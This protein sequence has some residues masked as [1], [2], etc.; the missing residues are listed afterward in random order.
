MKH[1]YVGLDDHQFWKRSP[2]IIDKSDLDP[3]TG[4]PFKISSIDK[5]VTAGSCF[6]QHVARFMSNSGFNHYITEK[7]HPAIIPEVSQRHNYG[8]FSARYGN[9]YTARQLKQLLLR[10]YGE[11]EPLV[12]AW[13]GRGAGTVV[14]P[15]RPQIAPGGF[16]SKRELIS[17]RNHHFSCI[18]KSI[19]D[20]D[21]FVFTLGL[22]EGWAD[23][24][25]GS[26]FPLAPGVAG[27]VYDPELVAF[28]NFDEVETYNDL[29]YSLEF[30][31][32]VNPKVRIILTVSPVP[33][34]ATYV[35]RHVLV[36][37]AWSKAV[38]RIA[39]EKAVAY[40]DNSAYFPSYEIIT[41]PHV[42]GAYYASDGREVLEDGVQHVM[43]LFMKHYTDVEIHVSPSSPAQ[44]ANDKHTQG[45]QEAVDILCDE[46]AIDN[47]EQQVRSNKGCGERPRRVIAEKLP[48]RSSW[49]ERILGRRK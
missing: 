11:F 13:P 31:R 24:R 42:R 28:S 36:S 12:A 3:V 21:V 4:T 40:F 39:A 9:I 22:T 34:N 35:D 44:L 1:P 49:W 23:T 15:F 14:D 46:A 16:T 32:R 25:D 37:T 19:E 41:S 2:G 45:M 7:A 26:I 8:M 18:R 29:K 48:D 43:R 5:I 33:L 47:V 38:L 20:M 27:G 6:A 30:I 10:A 17:D